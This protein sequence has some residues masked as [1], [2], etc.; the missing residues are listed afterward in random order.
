MKRTEVIEFD[1]PRIRE[2]V[3][4]AAMAE[5]VGPLFV[6]EIL[7]VKFSWIGER[8]D[9]EVRITFERSDEP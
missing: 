2:L 9:C 5:F 8:G 6:G 3:K 1:L 7:D 4:F